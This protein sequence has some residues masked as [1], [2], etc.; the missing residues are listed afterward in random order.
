MTDKAIKK[1]QVCQ[2]LEHWTGK[3]LRHTQH[4]KAV[5]YRLLRSFCGGPVPKNWLLYRVSEARG[6]LHKLD[7]E[8]QDNIGL[9]NRQVYEYL[10][11]VLYHYEH[12]PDAQRRF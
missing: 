8:R 6:I 2:I 11:P 9:A 5:E 4:D 3:A 7:L 1:A 10:D 12:T